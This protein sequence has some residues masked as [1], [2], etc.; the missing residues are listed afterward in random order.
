MLHFMLQSL[1]RLG[2]HPEQI[3]TTLENRMKCA[4]GHCGRCNIGP[5]Y[6]CRDGP[7]ITAAELKLLPPEV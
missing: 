1:D 3:V 7:V 6:V 5:F 4:L 2:F